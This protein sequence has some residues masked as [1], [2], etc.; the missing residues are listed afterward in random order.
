MDRRPLGKSNLLVTPLGFGAFKIGRNLASKYPRN[1]ELPDE[2]AAHQLLNDLLDLGITYVD[3]APAYGQ[4]EQRIGDALH[5]R[6]AEFTLSTKAGETFEDGKSNYDFSGGAITRSAERSLQR[7]R[8]DHIDL[9]LIHS[10]GN[11]LHI[12]QQTNAVDAMHALKQR[13]LTRAIGFSG[14]TSEGFTAA[15]DWADAIMVEFNPR[16]V[17][18]LP[19]MQQA[20]AR[21]VGVI[22]KKAL[23]SGHLPAAESI[24][25]VLSHDCVDSVVVGGLN[26]EHMRCNCE[27]AA[28]MSRKK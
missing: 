18:L 11:D 26:L 17:E 3:T 1:Y 24:R 12:L 2:A 16:N 10:D 7:L 13:G 22:V 20:H 5:H 23:A 19:V 28:S 6:R 8:T 27:V 14:K 21:G 25:F 4:S 15:L 9:L